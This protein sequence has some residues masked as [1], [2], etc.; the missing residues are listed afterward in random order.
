M[1]RVVGSVLVLA[2]LAGLVALAAAGCGTS[3]PSGGSTVVTPD[4]KMTVKKSG[5][6]IEVT[7][8]GKTKTWTT[9]TLAEKALGFPVPANAKLLS[10]T[11]IQVSSSSE[12]WQGATFY[13][14]D[15]VTTVMNYYKS[16][17]E[18]ESGYKDTSTTL[19]NQPVGCYSVSSGGT[20]KSV[21]VRAAESGEQ[22]KTWIQIATAT[23]AGV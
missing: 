2:L 14:N 3:Q 15:D 11:S 8:N 22:G 6:S 5:N 16:Q 12:K 21:I 1:R 9:A 7:K 13:S 19:S 17:L 20:I 10:G 18:K 4:G 23:G